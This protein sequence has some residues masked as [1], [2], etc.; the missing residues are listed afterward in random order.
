MEGGLLESQRTLMGELL[1]A[2]VEKRG[3]EAV[4]EALAMAGTK[5][6]RKKTS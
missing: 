3:R 6:Y 5:R 1:P 2:L 4:D